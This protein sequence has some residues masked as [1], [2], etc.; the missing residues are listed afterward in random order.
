MRQNSGMPIVP[1]PHP[2]VPTASSVDPSRS[3][4]ASRLLTLVHQNGTLSR[5][6][7]TKLT[8]LNRSTIGVLIGQ[9]AAQNLVVETAPEGEAQVGRPSPDVRPHPGVAA[10]A[11]NPEIDA[12]TIGLVGLG[13]R[14]A[15]MIRY[16]TGRIPSAAEAVN[17]AAAVI[18]GMRGE[19]DANYRITG[20]GIAVPGLVTTSDGMVR[21][22]PHL[23]WEN[24]PVARMLSDATGYPALVANDAS[25]AAEAEMVFGAGG[26][27]RNLVYLNGGASGIGGGVVS[28]GRLL[29]GVS[30]YAGEIGHTFVRTDGALCHCGARGCLETEVR[31]APL[32]ELLKLDAGDPAA[33][34]V[35]L[36]ASTDPGVVAEIHRQLGYLAIALRNVVNVFNPEAIVLDGFLAALHAAAPTELERAVTAQSMR[37]PAAQVHISGAALGPELMMVGA[38]ELAFAGLLADPLAWTTGR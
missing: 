29:A 8:G 30:G 18:A 3:N 16:P 38:A 28:E 7:L 1:P 34:A 15:K 26:G 24:E 14:V 23:G 27:I 31:Q 33:L 17:I 35:A 19:L 9:L 22:A 10:L 4:S 21:R 6:Q 2:V 36:G 12:V 25:L 20:I 32:F 5:A 37:E 13:G 11:V